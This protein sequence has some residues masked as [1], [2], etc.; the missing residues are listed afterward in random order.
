M[1]DLCPPPSLQSLTAC[2]SV[3]HVRQVPI[4]A[5]CVHLS[6]G[7]VHTAS[8]GIIFVVP[9]NAEYPSKR[10]PRAIPASVA[11]SVHFSEVAVLSTSVG[12]VLSVIPT[13]ADSPSEAVTKDSSSVVPE[14]ASDSPLFVAVMSTRVGRRN[15]GRALSNVCINESD[16][17]DKPR[18]SALFLQQFL[19]SSQL[20]TAIN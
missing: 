3:P 17:V 9:A 12:S 1:T 8:A 6:G 18:D 10:T 2:P 16:V 19:Y 14:Q 11:I 20:V 4:I 7:A 15:R 5:V 13:I